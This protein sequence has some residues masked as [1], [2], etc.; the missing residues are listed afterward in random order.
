MG[1]H[2]KE[3]EKEILVLNSFI[4]LVRAYESISSQ[5]YL[6]F[7][8]EGLTESQ[9]YAL[10]ALYHHKKVSQKEL[11]KKIWRSEGNV[12]MVVNNLAKQKLIE[13]KQSKDDKR[14]Y[15]IKL[16]SYGIDLYKKVFPK[17]LQTITMLFEE[18]TVEEHKEFQKVCI[19]IG[20]KS[21]SSLPTKD[22]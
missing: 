19:K 15:I 6:L 13:K 4:K 18:I 14:I 1:T 20:N 10:D 3:T 5:L 2:Y 21:N 7:K 12:T 8:K 22:L 16:T 17:F 9:F 11:S